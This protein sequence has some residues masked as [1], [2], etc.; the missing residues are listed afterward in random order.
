MRFILIQFLLIVLFVDSAYSSG[1]FYQISQSEVGE[2][3]NLYESL[4]GENWYNRDGWADLSASFSTS[5]IP[6]GL[7]L[8][9]GVVISSNSITTVYLVNVT[10]IYF[11]KNNLSGEIPELNLQKLIWLDLSDNNLNGEIPQLIAPQLER[12][13]LYNNQLAGNIP[14]FNNQNLTYLYLNRN[15][16]SGNI[17]DFNLPKLIDLILLG[18]KLSG[19]IPD[20]KLASLQR[21]DLS[22]NLLSGEIP[23]FD[24][25]DLDHL[26]LNNNN[27][28][29]EIPSFNLQNLRRLELSNN[30][31]IGTVPNFNMPKLYYLD[32]GY[33]NLSGELPDFDLPLMFFLYLG[34]NELSGEISRFEM[35]S[36]NNFNITKNKFTFGALEKNIDEA[37]IYQYETQDT[38][39]PIKRIDEK[40]FVTVDGSENSYHW[41]LDSNVVKS[42][43][44]NFYTPTEDGIYYCQVSNSLL[45]NLTLSSHTISV[46]NTSVDEQ[47][48][49]VKITQTN[50][51]INISTNGKYI[52]SEMKIFNNIGKIIYS[53][54]M[55]NSNESVDISGFATG[56]YN[57]I[58][59]KN[60]QIISSKKFII[61]K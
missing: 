23:D 19:E 28:S 55:L 59:V 4:G 20:F 30:E 34:N 9:A 25:P 14:N 48:N 5:E 1:A 60:N 44:V 17:P 10:G 32:L 42:T 40:I 31:L 21:L 16:L 45:P 24:L 2:L 39:L 49:D 52:G 18:N 3:E 36:L 27:I 8:E 22:T 50:G 35:P 61:V 38:I 12:L 7:G 33:N 26:I 53:G 51:Q 37:T 54:K 43:D 57:F 6:F 47:E 29:G 11:N 56:G 41:L 46:T 15:E 13:F 58:L